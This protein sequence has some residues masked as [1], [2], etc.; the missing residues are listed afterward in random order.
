MFTARLNGYPQQFLFEGDGSLSTTANTAV[1]SVP[2]TKAGVASGFTVF[3]FQ[4]GSPQTQTDAAGDTVK[5]AETAGKVTVD[6]TPRPAVLRSETP[7][8]IRG[9]RTSRNYYVPLNN[10]AA[11][12]PIAPTSPA[13]G[14]G[15]G[16]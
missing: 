15:T 3:F 16:N 9:S 13:S 8:K 7:F 14:S 5:I 12:P 1:G 11:I 4:S 2:T 6:V 10:Y